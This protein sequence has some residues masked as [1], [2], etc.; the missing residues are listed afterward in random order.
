L[1]Y[2]LIALRG[3]AL[4]Y[5]QERGS[6][7][8]RIWHRWIGVWPTILARADEVIECDVRPQLAQSVRAAWSQ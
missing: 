6:K 8:T 2:S 5:A 7:P 4:A 1:G 3:L